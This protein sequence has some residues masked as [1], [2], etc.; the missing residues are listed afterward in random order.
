[1]HIN[2]NDYLKNALGYVF[3]RLLFRGLSKSF[4]TLGH[5]IYLIIYYI[6]Y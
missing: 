3:N 1:M 4:V 5:Y 6:V 2:A